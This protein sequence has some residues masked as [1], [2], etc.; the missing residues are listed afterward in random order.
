[1]FGRPATRYDLDSH[2]IMTVDAGTGFLLELHGKERH[3]VTEAFT[4]PDALDP[5][6][7]GEETLDTDSE[8]FYSGH[9]SLAAPDCA[10]TSLTAD[11]PAC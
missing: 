1:M 4:I 5:A 2:G 6:I 11:V 7:F 9:L 8:S 10:V 3:L